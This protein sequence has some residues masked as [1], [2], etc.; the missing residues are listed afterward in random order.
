MDKVNPQ[1][2]HF[3]FWLSQFW[4]KIGTR[5]KK[6]PKKSVFYSLFSLFLLVS[7]FY[8][9]LYFRTTIRQSQLEVLI[10]QPN[11]S[12]VLEP[13]SYNQL[14]P[15]V[16]SAKAISVLLANP[17]TEN[18][19]KMLAILN[20]QEKEVNRKIYFYPLVYS[21]ST[22]LEQYQLSLEE[23]T[24][25][26]FEGGIEK[27]RLVFDSLEQAETTLIPELNR[28]PMWNLKNDAKENE[29]SD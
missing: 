10:F 27:N 18:Y 29:S 14:D 26:F 4:L 12:N 6:N 22:L 17:A 19:Q 20:E 3:S 25:V 8:S 13:I 16:K 11:E 2:R 21:D 1:N 28:L 9:L 24:F 7:F 5:L 15:T 23:V